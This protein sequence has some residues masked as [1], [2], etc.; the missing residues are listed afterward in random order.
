MQAWYGDG[1]D[2]REGAKPMACPHWECVRLQPTLVVAVACGDGFAM[3]VTAAGELLAWGDSPCGA[4]GIEG[5][6]SRLGA[7]L[8]KHS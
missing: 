1:G 5:P 7:Q 6:A 4:L 8:S 3:A 2:G